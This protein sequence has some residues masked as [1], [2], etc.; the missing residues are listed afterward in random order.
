MIG[1]MPTIGTALIRLPSGISPRCRKGTRSI[2]TATAKPSTQPAAHP[3]STALRKVCRKSLH[4][5][6]D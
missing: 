2:I 1:A 5:T 4:N 6:G 3:A